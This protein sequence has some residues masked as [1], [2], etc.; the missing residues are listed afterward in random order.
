MEQKNWSRAGTS[1]IIQTSAASVNDNES[2]IVSAILQ[3]SDATQ[4]GTALFYVAKCDRV[5]KACSVR[6][7][8]STQ[9]V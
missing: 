4:S 7:R 1:L 2:G 8:T 9:F 6:R 3:I 5:G